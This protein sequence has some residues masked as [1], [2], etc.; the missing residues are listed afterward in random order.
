MRYNDTSHKVLSVCLL[1]RKQ[2]AQAAE[3]AS[4]NKFSVCTGD[5]HS[6]VPPHTV[7]SANSAVAFNT[8][9]ALVLVLQCTHSLHTRW[10]VMRWRRG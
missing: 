7:L 1:A 5:R 10:A 3:A 8:Y 2:D 9:T 6:Q 4:L